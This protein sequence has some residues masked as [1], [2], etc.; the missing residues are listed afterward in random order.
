M[1]ANSTKDISVEAIVA[2][3]SQGRGEAIAASYESSD[4]RVALGGL[5][6]T[7]GDKLDLVAATEYAQANNRAIVATMAN[8][9]QPAAI[10]NSVNDT[11]AGW[12]SQANSALSDVAGIVNSTV[13]STTTGAF[14]VVDHSVTTRADFGG[15]ALLEDPVT[16]DA[17]F[18]NAA[19][20]DPDISGGGTARLNVKARNHVDQLSGASVVLLGS[21]ADAGSAFITALGS[22]VWRLKTAAEIGSNAVVADG[23]RALVQ[24]RSD[25]PTIDDSGVRDLQRDVQDAFASPADFELVPVAYQLVPVADLFDE[26]NYITDVQV[27]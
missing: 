16:G 12:I 8:P 4:V 22:D 24:A 25:L 3:D 21:A 13:A 19:G 17:G 26:A 11:L 1:T 5:V 6:T 20:F 7:T 14:T 15:V 27:A 2:A 10:G 18:L 23:T 9:S